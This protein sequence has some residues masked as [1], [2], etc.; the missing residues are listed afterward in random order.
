MV[1]RRQFLFLA[2]AAGAAGVAAVTL[3]E[4]MRDDAPE[5]IRLPEI[6]FGQESCV[7]CGMLIDDV[8]FAAAWTTPGRDEAHF[9]DIGCM[10]GEAEALPAPADAHC[11]VADYESGEW[12]A[13]EDAFYVHSPEIRSPMAYGLA[14]CASGEAA[15]R[16]AHA[17]SGR[18]RRWRDLP[19]DLRGAHHS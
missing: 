12:L 18:V 16:L 6:A 5:G 9:D 17:T 14:A 13:A 11:F 8:R 15:D 19:H 4:L 10:V 1:S 3:P 2:G 7:H